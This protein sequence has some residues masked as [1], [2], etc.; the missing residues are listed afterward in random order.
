MQ[1]FAVLDAF[2]GLF[3]M[4]IVFFHMKDYNWVTDNSFVNNSDLFVN[5][6][7]VLSGFVIA[8]VYYD[9]INSG[10][11]LFGFVKNRFKRIYPLHLYTLLVFAAFELTKS[12]LYRQGYFEHVESSNNTLQSFLANIFLLNATPAAGGKGLSWNYPSWSI[13]AEF[14]TYIFF[15]LLMYLLRKSRAVKTIVSA[16]IP[17]LM[18]ILSRS[19]SSLV[20]GAVLG[21]FTGVIVYRLYRNYQPLKKLN[22]AAGTL[23]EAAIFTL[24]VIMI[25]NKPVFLNCLYVYCFLFALNIYIFSFELG[26]I[27]SFLKTR[28]F[29]TMGKYSYSIYLNHAIVIEVVNFLLVRLLKLDGAVLYIVP[30]IIAALTF[31]YSGLTYRFIEARFYKRHAHK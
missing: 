31:A 18:I 12:Y 5:F 16:A 2:R 10:T 15:G 7:F 21:F 24:T 27:S 1:R 14:I 23:L 4:M 30:F 22:K 9:R 17:L 3:A 25:C 19:I 20:F 6:F 26:M 28:F 8:F 11:A 29:Q 13:S